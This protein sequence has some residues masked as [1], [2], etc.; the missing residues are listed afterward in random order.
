MGTAPIK[1]LVTDAF[2]YSLGNSQ[3]F[4]LLVYVLC[5]LIS[6]VV[7]RFCQK[8]SLYASCLLQVNSTV[9]SSETSI[10]PIIGWYQS[11]QSSN[12]KNEENTLQKIS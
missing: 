9:M 6:K 8:A 10:S 4:I 1:T 3:H 12:R 5:P 7:F 11:M 2:L